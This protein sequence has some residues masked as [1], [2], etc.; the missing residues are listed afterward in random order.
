MLE[1]IYQY[2][3]FYLY[4]LKD[5]DEII[6]FGHTKDLDE[7]RDK[8]PHLTV[9]RLGDKVTMSAT[10]KWEWEQAKMFKSQGKK[11]REP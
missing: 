9:E 4:Y 7:I 11:R 5:G 8:N 2:K 3:P 10:A 6:D 1:M